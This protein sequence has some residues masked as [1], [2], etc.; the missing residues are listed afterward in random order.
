M[1][2]LPSIYKNN[3]VKST[4][5]KVF[6][7]LKTEN[8]DRS[9]T[10]EDEVLNSVDENSILEKLNNLFQNRKHAY[11]DEVVIKTKNGIYQ[12]RLVFM[13]DRKVVTIDNE[14]IYLDDIVSI[15]K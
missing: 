13:T 7:S 9:V 4:N 12:T 10:F 11:T 6:Y 3:V 1:K 15:Q 2:K 5:K 8:S 14:E